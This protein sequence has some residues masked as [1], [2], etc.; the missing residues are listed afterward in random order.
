MPESGSIMGMVG[1]F[2]GIAILLSIGIQILGNSVQDCTALP[3][4]NATVPAANNTNPDGTDVTVENQQTGWA[5]ACQNTNT[6]SQSAYALLIIILIV[7]AAVAI[8]YVVR[9]L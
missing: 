3:D 4:W 2:I 7:I 9:M 5:L 8:L 1:A 6:Q